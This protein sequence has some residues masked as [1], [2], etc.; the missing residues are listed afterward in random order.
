[1]KGDSQ[2]NVSII[3]SQ[4]SAKHRLY[5]SIT[6][7][8]T[9]ITYESD[10]LGI[11]VDVDGEIL[12]DFDATTERAVYGKSLLDLLEK[13]SGEWYCYEWDETE[14]KASTGFHLSK[15]QFIGFIKME[16]NRMREQLAKSS[17]II[18]TTRKM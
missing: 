6:I 13:L 18:S 10:G 2:L 15:E 9:G 4:E 14:Q 11:I 1:M 7:K 8:E 16:L 3:C 12:A 17:K 5:R